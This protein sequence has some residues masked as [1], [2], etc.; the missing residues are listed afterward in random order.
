MYLGFRL[1]RISGFLGSQEFG[2]LKSKLCKTTQRSEIGSA[3]GF[4]AAMKLL[5]GEAPK[6]RN[7]IALTTPINHSRP[8]I[9]IPP[10]RNLDIA[11]PASTAS[12]PLQTDHIKQKAF[13]RQAELLPLQWKPPNTRTDSNRWG[14]PPIDYSLIFSFW[15]HMTHFNSLAAVKIKTWSQAL[16]IF[17]QVGGKTAP[18]LAKCLNVGMAAYKFRTLSTHLLNAAYE[19]CDVLQ[20]QDP[21]LPSKWLPFLPL[22]TSFPLNVYASHCWDLTQAATRIHEP[23]WQFESI[24]IVTLRL[25]VP[26]QQTSLMPSM[27][28][29]AS[30]IIPHL[31][32]LGGFQF[33]HI[34]NCSIAESTLMRHQTRSPAS[35]KFLLT[36]GRACPQMKF[37]HAYQEPPVPKRDFLQ[38]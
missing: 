31:M 14:A 23:N 8:Q 11:H 33:L 26:P 5:T 27:N 1:F 6:I 36:L 32:E 22:E 10:P 29:N 7:A 17:I 18:F 25:S 24:T 37:V 9:S 35:L 20:L 21:P 2:E 12:P 3:G 4:P 34:K 28:V 19:H 15:S 13:T 16:A 30:C 38:L